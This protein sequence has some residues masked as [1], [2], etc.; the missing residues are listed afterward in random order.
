MIPGRRERRLLE[1]INRGVRPRRRWPVLVFSVLAAM[2]L[3]TLI[4]VIVW[5]GIELLWS[6]LGL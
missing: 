5:M 6:W 4:L 1:S 3:T 2:L